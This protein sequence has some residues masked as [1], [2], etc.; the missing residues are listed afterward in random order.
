MN[1]KVGILGGTGPEGK[2]LAYRWAR[3]GEEIVIGS[4]DAQR[5]AET[6]AQLRAR[7]GGSARIAEADNLTTAAQCD[8]VV[9]TVPFSGCAALLKQ[10]KSVWKPGTVVIDT[11][12]PLAA[13]VGG[14]ATRMLGVWQGSA[15]EQTRE[16][17]PAGV[18]VVAAFQNLGAELLSKDEPVD[19]DILVCSDDQGAKEVASELAGKIPGARAINGGKLENARIV[20]SLTALLIGLNM[21]YKVHSAGI[22]FTGLPIPH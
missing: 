2:G 8:V 17:V 5:A 11:T 19:C 10:L 21:R 3:A 7:I 20:E 6:A 14:A 18:S 13:T 15:A 1:R 16:L 12:V 22:R 4:R 9:L